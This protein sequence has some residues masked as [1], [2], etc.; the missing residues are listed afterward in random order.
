MDKGGI[1]NEVGKYA[2]Q[3]REPGNWKSSYFE[4]KGL[5]LTLSSTVIYYY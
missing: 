1:W 4:K 2:G 5:S 3:S